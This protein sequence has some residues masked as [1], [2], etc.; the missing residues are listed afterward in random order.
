VSQGQSLRHGDLG[1]LWSGDAD[2]LNAVLEKAGGKDT[3]D[4][5]GPEDRDRHVCAGSEIRLTYFHSV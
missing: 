1:R 3:A 2:D 4:R 5:A